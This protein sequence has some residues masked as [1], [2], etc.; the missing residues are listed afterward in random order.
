MSDPAGSN[1]SFTIGSHDRAAVSDVLVRFAWT[2]D[3]GGEDDFL[4]FFHD[5]ASWVM[6]EQAWTGRPQIVAG[7]MGLREAGFAGP[8]SRAR[9]LVHNVVL[10]AIDH[11]R[12]SARSL[13]TLV[14]EGRPPHVR[15]MGIYEDNLVRGADGW[16]ILTRV[17]HPL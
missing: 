17:V 9:H 1:A 14:A 6:G 3:E 8:A 12:I 15:A 13:F 7:L 16:V 10:S 11:E 2:A 4:P 5:D